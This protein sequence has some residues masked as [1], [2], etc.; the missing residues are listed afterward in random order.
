[1]GCPAVA[2][3]AIR[4][5]ES[6]LGGLCHS[7]VAVTASREIRIQRI[8]G[9]ENISRD[10]AETRVGAQQGEDFYIA[11]AQHI[12]NSDDNTASQL[13]QRA[14]HIFEKII[15]ETNI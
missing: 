2:I 11:H 1:M 9:R 13:E 4:L 14:R 5:M 7:V 8:M 10:Y 3:D 6:G 15:Q 12:L